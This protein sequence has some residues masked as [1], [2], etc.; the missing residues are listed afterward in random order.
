M[1]LVGWHYVEYDGFEWNSGN[2]AK[3]QKHGVSLFEIEH[4]FEQE[5]LIIPDFQN[6]KQEIRFIAIGESTEARPLF[7]V[8]TFREKGAESHIRII[9]ARYMHRQGKEL[10]FYEKLKKSFKKE[11]RKR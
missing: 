5:I 1:S 6:S 8:F 2:L 9:S 3:V 7:V 10:E 11:S 4:F